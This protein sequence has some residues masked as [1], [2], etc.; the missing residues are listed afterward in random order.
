VSG[1][2]LLAP[3]GSTEALDAAIGE[4]AD[5][6]YLGLKTFNARLR[7]SNFAYSQFEAAVKTLQ[8]QQRKIYVTVNTV[9]EQ[10][11]ADRMYQFLKYLAAVGPA[12]IIVQDFGVARLARECFPDL[13]VHAST[14]MN[15]ASAKGVNLL[16]K[17]GI[18]RVVLARELG[19]DEIKAIKDN[20]SAELEVFVHGALCVSGSGICL[21]SSYL[22]GKSANRGMCAQACR[23]RYSAGRADDLPENRAA[24]DF[25]SGEAAQPAAEA[26]YFFS[27]SD[28]ELIDR[29]GDLADA[30]VASL[31]IE[32][33]MKS[34]EYVG[35]VVAAYRRMIDGLDGDREKALAEARAILRNDF[36]RTKTS[37]Y[38][39]GAG[40][41]SWLDSDQAGG[42]GIALGRLL[43]VRGNE[44]V[45]LIDPDGL[46][47]A[48]GD[49]ARFHRADDSERKS[50]KL[51]KV[52]PAGRHERGVWIDVPEGFAA[53]DT[54]YLIQT[55]AM[56]KRYPRVLPADL[57]GFRRLPGRDA[58][59]ELPPPQRTEEAKP[60]G[61]RAAKEAAWPDGLYVAVGKPEDLYVAQAVR[62]VKAILHYRRGL[63]ARL[64]DAEPLPFPKA[65]LIL[66]LDP[67]FPQADDAVLAAELKDLAEA[68]YRNYIVNNLGHLACLRGSGARMI[69]GPY[70]Y[71]FNTYAFDFVRSLGLGQAVTPL[72]NNRQ[73]L[74]RSIEPKARRD[75][76]VTAF[77]Y[78]ALFRI[79]AD[80]TPLY[81]FDYFTDGRGDTFRLVAGRDG[82]LVLPDQPF[83]IVDKLPFLREAGFTKFILDF[84]GPPIRKRDYKDV[85]DAAAEGRPLINTT[86]F[87]WKDGFF[88]APTEG[89]RPEGEGRGARGGRD[90]ER[91]AG[92]PEPG[93]RRGGG[94]S[95]K[96]GPARPRRDR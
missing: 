77:A 73:N 31:K 21:Y 64:L 56:T 68:G 28:L 25:G 46:A 84:S 41:D 2:E 43:K 62:P 13:K 61:G 9:F 44:G 86:R 80:L 8:R 89:A 18:S 75:V 30:G 24:F 93:G 6:V 22:G 51:T 66:S 53:G 59:P 3:A 38:W 40:P 79:R 76:F 23:R 49:T 29:V 12:G 74:E 4:G 63:A 78:P 58:A 11:E 83:S 35:T 71:T 10:R 27:P 32:G 60:S 5:A 45:G 55:K 91:P 14:Q 50:L 85:M 34:A 42:T 15:V 82:S 57:G 17:Y 37:F 81:A 1:I 47:P 72:E 54:V 65:D 96:P 33:R 69:A 67:Y 26:G 20:S 48:A 7:S 52:E 19:F 70:L 92:V 87:N 36:A 95:R 94:E 16:S 88:Q 90:W 39:D